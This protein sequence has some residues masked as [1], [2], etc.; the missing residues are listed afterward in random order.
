MSEI[1]ILQ[2]LWQQYTN[3]NPHVVEIHELFLKKNTQIIND[4]IA[5]R[6][7]NDSRIDIEV[8]AKPFI[9][10][11]YFENGEYKF[12]AKKL[13]AKHYQHKDPT[14]PKIFISQ[15]LLQEFTPF[16]QSIIKEVVNTIPPSLLDNPAKL[17]LSGASWDKPN[18]EVYQALLQESEYAAWFY[19]FGFRANHFTVFINALSQFNEVFEVNNFLKDHGFTLNESGGEIKGT[20][21]DLLEQSSTKSGIIAVDFTEGSYQIPC[22]Y[23]EFAKR[24]PEENGQLYQGFVAAS[25]DKI[26]ESTNVNA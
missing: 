24:Y 25:A 12:K 23:Y 10:E 8:L 17:L 22:C 15:L 16:T 26:F 19:I 3:D 9:K 18:Y 5:L 20:P 4:H 11:G 21:T 1:K 13:F 14:K 2:Q 7:I 6:T